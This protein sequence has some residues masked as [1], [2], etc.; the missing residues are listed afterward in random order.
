[1]I[2]VAGGHSHTA[3]LFGNGTVWC[4]GRNDNGQLG[5]GQDEDGLEGGPPAP[6]QS[7]LTMVK[8]Y[9]DDPGAPAP[10]KQ[11]DPDGRGPLIP[12]GMEPNCPRAIEVAAG[13]Y[14]TIATLAGGFTTKGGAS[15]QLLAWGRDLEGQLGWGPFG[16]SIA[17]P[18][19]PR[20]VSGIQQ[21]TGLNLANVVTTVGGNLH[22]VALQG[23]GRPISWGDDPFGQLGW[24][25]YMILLGRPPRPPTLIGLNYWQPAYVA[26][27]DAPFRPYPTA[28]PEY[29][30]LPYG[31]AGWFNYR[32]APG[33]KMIETGGIT[34]VSEQGPTSDT[35]RVVL[36]AQ[37]VS[38]VLVTCTPDNQVDLGSGPGIPIQLTFLAPALGGPPPTWNIPQTV[39]VTAVDDLVAQGDR[40]ST[41]THTA[42]VFSYDPNDPDHFPLDPAYDAV[43]IRDVEVTVIDND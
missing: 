13:D 7:L 32:I 31:E 14:H 33:V 28:P 26:L 42:S 16:G 9:N 3:A 19:R 39:T 22:T 10:Q 17:N 23:F 30:G 37:P 15:S 35:Y 20:L 38:N 8:M 1:M 27:W 2:H 6:H 29:G 12:L 43:F 5:I 34:R 18:Q 36:N 24:D 11:G 40:T 21:Q 25:D 4:T 41:I